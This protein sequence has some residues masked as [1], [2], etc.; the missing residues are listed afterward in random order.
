MQRSVERVPLVGQRFAHG[1]CLVGIGD[2]ELENVGLGW[3]LSGGALGEPEASTGAGE[4]DLGALFL[5]EFCCSE[6]KR[7]V[8]EDTGDEESFSVE[9]AHG[10]R[11]YI[12]RDAVTVLG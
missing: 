12:R 11:P 6:C 4:D 5:C 7:G 1:Y 9:K 2:V 10:Q 8:G 3:Q